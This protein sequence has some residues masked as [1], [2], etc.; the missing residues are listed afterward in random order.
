MNYVCSAGTGSFLEEQARKLGFDIKKVSE[1]IIGISPPLT[2]ERCTVFME[3]DIENLL[4]EGFSKKEVMASCIYSVVYNYLNKVV[5][6][7]YIPE[8]KI[9]FQGATARNKALIAGF[10]NVCGREIVVS[11]FCHVMGAL[12]CAIL[13]KEN[14]KGKTNF[15]GFN[16]KDE[17]VKIWYENC[18]LCENRCK[19]TYLEIK[20]EILSYGYQ[21]GREPEEKRKKEVKEVYLFKNYEENLFKFNI[22]TKNKDKEVFIPRVLS[23]YLLFPFYK[24]FLENIGFKVLIS[25]NPDRELIKKGIEI[26]TS[27]FCL[28]VK[29]LFGSIFELLEKGKYIFLPWVI[30][31]PEKSKNYNYFC[32]YVESSPLLIINSPFLKEKDKEKLISP[33]FD[34]SMKENILIKNLYEYFKKFGIKIKEIEKAFKKALQS[35]KIFEEKIKK[36]GEKILEEINKGEKFIIL[37]GRPYIIFSNALNLSIPLKF[38]NLGIK[39]LPWNYLTFSSTKENPF[40]NMY[41]Y[42]GEKILRVAEFVKEKENLFPL[43]LS[44]FSCGPDS[45]LISYLEEIFKDKPFLILEMD[46]HGG[47]AVFQT[48]IEA[49]YDVIKEYK[50]KK[51]EVLIIKKEKEKDVYSRII[52]IPPMH[53]DG[54]RLF[55]ASFRRFGFKAK[56]LPLSSEKDLQTGRKLLRGSECLPCAL[57]LGTFINEIKNFNNEKHTLFMPTSS[58]PCRFGQYRVLQKMI[59][60]REN[61]DV[62]ILSPNSYNAYEGLPKNLRKFLWNA[63]LIFDAL[64][65]MRNRIKPYEKNKGE[66]EKVYL[67]SIKKMEEAIEKGE[68]VYKVFEECVKEFKNIEKID[69]KKPLIGIVGE[70]YVRLDQFSNENVIQVIEKCGGEA[71]LSP[72][73]EW[74]WYTDFTARWRAKI[75]NNLKEILIS[76]LKNRFFREVEE[77]IYEIGGEILKDRKEPDIEEIMKRAEEFMPLNFGTETPLTIGRAIIFKEQGA[78]AVINVAPFTCMPGNITQAVFQGL[79]EKIGIPVINMFYDGKRG[80]NKNLERLL[81]FLWS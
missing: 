57:T 60:E 62:N 5:G 65:K 42:Y 73:S 48:R 9:F 80:E 64:L 14:I 33:V 53:P 36:E 3:E 28:P 1:E 2:Q 51:K 26:S 61:M 66:T 19:I 74:I 7:R 58:G 40:E 43:Y 46:E 78:K 72:V 21:C 6:K 31:F 17:N 39:V 47:E 49:F 56:A 77:R 20:D 18:P 54:A 29:I 25:K 10:E 44:T 12:G 38:A 63:I 45:F 69:I 30:N 68:D 41:W 11:P 67:F 34:F 71:W 27:E 22:D 37:F 23:T 16:I 52:W 32:P 8:G 59:F 75:K 76:F 4:K 55:A 35:Q 15:R 50:E 81:P 13:V 70:I 79:G 24:T